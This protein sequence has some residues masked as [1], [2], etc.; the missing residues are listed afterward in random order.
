MCFGDVLWLWF[1]V[2]W[3]CLVVG[4]LLC[5]VCVVWL[6]CWFIGIFCL[7]LFWVGLDVF[8]CDLG[9]VGGEGVVGFFNCSLYGSGVDRVGVVNGYLGGVVSI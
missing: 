4:V 1:I 5:L 7:N 3:L 9:V 8:R 6:L 2:V